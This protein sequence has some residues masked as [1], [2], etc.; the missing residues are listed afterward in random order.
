M[1]QIEIRKL[2]QFIAVA[3][4][5]SFRG[6]ADRLHMAQP[7]LSTAIKQLEDS[8]GARLFERSKTFVRLTPAGQVFLREAYRLLKQLE[9]ASRLARNAENGIFGVIRVSFVP[10]A[11]Y[12]YIPGLARS[13]GERYPAVEMQLHEG[14][15]AEVIRAV[16]RGEADVGF[17]RH[18]PPSEN[19]LET[20]VC[21]NES[22][23]VVLP[24]S[25]PLAA[26]DEIT[27]S[28]L[29]NDDFISL[30]SMQSPNFRSSFISACESAGFSPRVRHDAFTIAT[31][32]GLV[33]AGLGVALVPKSA[34]L[35]MHPDVRF[36]KLTDTSTS[37]PLLAIW[38]GIAEDAI[39]GN[40]LQEVRNDLA[41]PNSASAH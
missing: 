4:E 35:F 15:T 1:S 38:K 11:G 18:I 37:I 40:F 20:I 26:A 22:F 19:H 16:H 3:E 7:P 9:N 27:L 25:H 5:L 41:Q 36:C 29:A 30:H 2:R 23:L 8:V 17:V 31:M 39:V 24:A 32:I 28:S 10:S 33:S 12:S 13:F 21:R 6:A 14:V 34:N